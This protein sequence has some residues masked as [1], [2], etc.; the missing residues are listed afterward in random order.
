MSVDA[1]YASTGIKLKTNMHT[2]NAIKAAVKIRG[3]KL[4]TVKFSLPKQQNVIFAARSELLVKKNGKEEA[5]IGVSTG[6]VRSACFFWPVVRWYLNKTDPTASVY[7]FEYRWARRR[8]V[9]VASLTFDTPGSR[10]KTLMSG[11]LTIDKHTLNMTMLMQSSAGEMVARAQCKNTDDEKFLRLALDINKK[12]HFDTSVSLFRNRIRNGFAYKPKVYLG[13]SVEFINKR[14]ISQYTVDLKF[15]TKRLNSKL[16]GYISKSDASVEINLYNDYKFQ[17]M[18]EHRVSFKFGMANRS[19]KKHVHTCRVLQSKL[20]RLS[21]S[22]LCFKRHLPDLTVQLFQN[23]LP[24]SHPQAANQTLRFNL[25]ISYKTY[26]DNKRTLLVQAGVNRNSSNLALNGEFRYESFRHDINVAA[27]VKYSKNKQV[28][29]ALFWSH[30][31]STLGANQDAHQRRHGGDLVQRHSMTAVAMYQDKSKGLSSDHHVKLFVQS[32]HFKEV[33]ANL[34]FYRDNDVLKVDLNAVQNSNNYQLFFHHQNVSPEETKTQIRVKYKTKVYKFLSSVYNGDHRKIHAELR[35]DQLRDIDF[36][37]WI[38]NQEAHKAFGFD[39]NWD[40]NRDPDQKL[41]LSTNYTR[42]APFNHV[43]N[44]ILSYPSRTVIANYK[45]LLEPGTVKTLASISWD[46][47]KTLAIDL[48]VVYDYDGKVYL[49]I[50]SKLNTPFDN[51]KVMQLEGVLKHSNNEY[52]LYGVTAWDRGQKVAVDFY[53]DYT[54]LGSHFTCKYSCSVTSSLDRIPNINTTVSHRQNDTNFDSVLHLMYNP[55]FVIDLES[56]W[57][58]ESD[59]ESTNL[60]GT[61]H[62]QTPFKGLKKG[63]LV[64]KIFLKNGNYVKG[65]AHVDVDNKKMTSNLEGK[66]VKITNCWLTVNATAAKEN[67]QLRFK[68]STEERHIVALLTYPTDSFGTEVLFSVNSLSN[69]DVKLHLATPV[70][71]LRMVVVMAKLK[72]EEPNPEPLKDLGIRMENVY[73]RSQL[74]QVEEEDGDDPLSW[75]GLIELDVIIYPT[76]KGELEIDQK[77]SSYILQSNLVMSHGVAVIIDEFKYIDV[78]NMTNDLQI[79][80]PYETF[81]DIVSNFVL[82]IQPS[83]KYVFGLNLDYL[84]KTTT[85]KTG[86]YAKYIFDTWGRGEDI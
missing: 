80:T 48:N 45:F 46:D 41:M 27:L 62:S 32:P 73:S 81:K 40:A 28:S 14:G 52:S 55:D 16:F 51:W 36:S 57:K 74:S 21:Q 18:Q 68:V 61:I 20:N 64:S 43:A 12:K 54:Y 84:N 47:G 58:I 37:I 76:M 75:K 63:V 15:E 65:V 6:K 5:Q 49:E 86:V 30:P 33:N 35:I 79:T 83:R 7:S 29:V 42:I 11:N 23:P 8:D 25:L 3:T 39:I 22:Q 38:Y 56:K 69:F 19:R 59:R 31:R 82:E 17:H 26:I 1:F 66:F 78:F 44:F 70:E 13:R 4:A 67:Y 9:S 34:Q 50:V 71:F 60:T 77:G 2:D 53:G 85:V 72:P 10:M 24:E